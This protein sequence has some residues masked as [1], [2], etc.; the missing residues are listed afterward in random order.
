MRYLKRWETV[1]IW[2]LGLFFGGLYGGEWSHHHPYGGPV[3]G[4]LLGFGIV[5]CLAVI[6]RIDGGEG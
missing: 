4:A 3:L 6:I 5:I 1:V 2:S